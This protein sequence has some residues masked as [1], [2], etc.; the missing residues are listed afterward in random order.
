MC[1]LVQIFKDFIQFK[2]KKKIGYWKIASINQLAII[3]TNYYLINW[4][5]RK[6]INNIGKVLRRETLA[7][8]YSLH[9]N[10]RAETIISS[11][12]AVALI[13]KKSMDK[14]NIQVNKA[15]CICVCCSSKKRQKINQLFR[16]LMLEIITKI[17]LLFI[18]RASIA[19]CHR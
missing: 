1:V 15:T 14:T 2:I 6:S 19:T 12:N 5:E 16:Q 13:E 18:L 9:K 4:G 17:A 10:K 7:N 3:I 11:F 8:N